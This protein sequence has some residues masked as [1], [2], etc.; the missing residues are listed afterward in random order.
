VF[1]KLPV[2]LLRRLHPPARPKLDFQGIGKST[3]MRARK[4]SLGQ[5]KKAGMRM[6][7]G[8][9]AVSFH[10]LFLGGLLP[11]RARFRFAGC[12]DGIRRRPSRQATQQSGAL[13][14]S[15]QG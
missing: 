5:T 11:S 6:H 2:S 13:S 9:I 10:R 3:A 1:A 7:T 12:C 15:H 14:K 8:L 4:G